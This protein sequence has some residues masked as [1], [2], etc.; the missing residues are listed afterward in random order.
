MNGASVAEVSTLLALGLGDE[1][2]ANQQAYGMSEVPGRAAAIEKL[3][4]GNQF[5][6]RGGGR[7]VLIRSRARPPSP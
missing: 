4:A 5:R 7:S 1:I 3:P 2:V 6:D